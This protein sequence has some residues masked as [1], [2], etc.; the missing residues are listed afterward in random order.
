LPPKLGKK[1]RKNAVSFCKFALGKREPWLCA[2]KRGE[3]KGKANSL[4]ADPNANLK[5]K[6][7][8]RIE[9]RTKG[10]SMMNFLFAICRRRCRKGS[11]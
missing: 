11:D 4:T 3:G 6:G 7:K 2:G 8:G 1:G 10:R 5:G 9:P